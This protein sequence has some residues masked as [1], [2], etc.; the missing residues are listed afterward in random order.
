MTLRCKRRVIPRFRARAG[1]HPSVHLLVQRLL[2]LGQGPLL[3][4]GYIAT[5]LL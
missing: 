2:Q 3:D 5:R 4:A 1:A